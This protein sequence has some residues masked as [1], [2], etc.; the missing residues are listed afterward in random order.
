MLYDDLLNNVREDNPSM[1]LEDAQ[2]ALSQ[3]LETVGHLISANLVA[4][5][6]SELPLPC[7]A[8]LHQGL[9]AS[10]SARRLGHGHG[11]CIPGELPDPVLA[12]IH[13]VCGVLFH[14][15]PLELV[16][17]VDAALP[18]PLTGVFSRHAVSPAQP[19]KT[20]SAKSSL[21]VANHH[22]S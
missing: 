20:T 16:R 3:T 15:L 13:A 4:A 1:S 8:A 10:D 5:L 17:S 14:V 19:G 7:A 22:E 2:R 6:A 9:E 11:A 12:Q 21:R 18:A